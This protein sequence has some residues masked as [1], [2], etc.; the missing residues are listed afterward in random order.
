MTCLVV[1]EVSCSGLLFIDIQQIAVIKMYLMNLKSGFKWEQMNL[2]LFVILLF[3]CQSP[4]KVLY[5]YYLIL[6]IVTFS[7]LVSSK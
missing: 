4:C 7:I 5:I 3:S 6:I 2:Y 1:K